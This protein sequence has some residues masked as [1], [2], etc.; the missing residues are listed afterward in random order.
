M[1]EIITD[2]IQQS[3][4][5]VAK[6]INKPQKSRISSPTRALMTK[7]REMAENGDNNQE[8]CKTIKKKARKDVRKYNP[9][10]IRDTI[11]APKS[12]KKVRRTLKLCQDR[13]ITLLGKQGR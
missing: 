9:E 8:I 1:S 5:R 12:L 13:L 10:I 6:V 11:I 3:A 4:S 7:R 2:M